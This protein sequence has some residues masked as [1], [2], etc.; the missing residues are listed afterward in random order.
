MSTIKEWWFK[1][2]INE[3]EMKLKKQYGVTKVMIDFY[4][5]RLYEKE[6]EQPTEHNEWIPIT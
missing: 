3:K 4:D 6:V 1:D 2:A 5:G